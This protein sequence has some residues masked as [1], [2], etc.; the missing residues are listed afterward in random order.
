MW[1]NCFKDYLKENSLPSIDL[2]SNEQLADV[3]CDFYVEVKK[4]KPNPN[5]QIEV[6]DEG[7]TYFAPPVD[8]DTA[9]S[10]KTSTLRLI[11]GALTR[12]FKDTRKLDIRSN[13]LFIEANEMFIGKTK[14][15]KEKGLGNINNKPPIEDPDLSKLYSYFQS[16]MQKGVNPKVLQ[17]SVLFFVT[18]YLCRRGREN[19]RTM[20]KSTFEVAVDTQNK[21]KYIYQAIDEA[22]KNHS[23]KDTDIANQG[24]IYEVP[25]T[26]ICYNILG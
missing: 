20:T 25:G 22:D 10:Y 17:Q 14:H 8:E 18:Y 1:V 7:D 11:R 9:L 16:E 2:I 15:N 6:K 23:D 26:N 12:Y 13:D 5:D 24:R 21:K 3:L 19:L 4:K